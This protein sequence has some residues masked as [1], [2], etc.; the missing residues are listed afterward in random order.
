M[1]DLENDIDIS[2]IDYEELNV[3]STTLLELSSS[4]KPV[5]ALL[6]KVPVLS[7][8]EFVHFKIEFS[9]SDEFNSIIYTLNTSDSTTYTS[10][11]NT[12]NGLKVFTGMSMIGFP[13]DGIGESFSKEVIKLD[14]SEIGGNYYRFQWLYGNEGS[15][16]LT[17][18]KYGFGQTNMM[19]SI[20]DEI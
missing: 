1:S 2:N 11:N 8:D 17:P 10:T 9:D 19:M 14:I 18:G 20:Y 12:I 16:D 5:E 13:T 15:N 4:I 7:G 3:L 6:F